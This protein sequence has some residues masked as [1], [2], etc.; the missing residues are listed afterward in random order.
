LQ[1]IEHY[2][3]CGMVSLGDQITGSALFPHLLQAAEA[4][5]E[6]NSAQLGCL[7]GQPTEPLKFTAAKA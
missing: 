2:R 1:E 4:L 5:A 6:L 7:P 3:L